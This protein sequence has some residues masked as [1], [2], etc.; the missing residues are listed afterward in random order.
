M[1][2]KESCVFLAVEDLHFNRK[3]LPHSIENDYLPLYLYTLYQK[4]QLLAFSNDLMRE[5]AQVDSRLSGARALLRRFVAFRSQYWFSEVT[6]KPMGGDLYRTMLHGLEAPALY[7][8]V[9]ASVKEAQ[10]YYEGVWSRQMQWV[11]D[12]FTYGGPLVVLL[13]SVRF[14]LDGPDTNRWT[15]TV[16]A[17]VGVAAVVVLYVRWRGRRPARGRRRMKKPPGERP[18]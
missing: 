12:A 10:E 6:R 8:L 17:A 5:V 18:A 11:R 7:E 4:F 16:L 1:V 14:L 3:S 2:L 9:T 15:L 13:A